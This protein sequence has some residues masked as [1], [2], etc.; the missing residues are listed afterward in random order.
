[1]WCEF[2]WLENLFVARGTMTEAAAI[3]GTGTSTELLE[4]LTLRALLLKIIKHIPCF[5]YIYTYILVFPS[6]SA[7]LVKEGFVRTL[8][9]RIRI[10][11]EAVK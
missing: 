4:S 9:R 3:M 7:F 11:Q 10:A 1:M 8:F 6:C 2:V 5:V